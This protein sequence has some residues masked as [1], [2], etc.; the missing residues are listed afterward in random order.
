M[1]RSES[2][3]FTTVF[4]EKSD[5]QKDTTNMFELKMEEFEERLNGS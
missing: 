1:K 2:E 5:F 3:S 4:L